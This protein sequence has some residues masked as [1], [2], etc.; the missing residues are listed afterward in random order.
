MVK[1]QKCNQIGWTEVKPKKII[2]PNEFFSSIGF[3]LSAGSP[4]KS[5]GLLKYQAIDAV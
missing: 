1:I 2:F 3:Q 4:I 5:L